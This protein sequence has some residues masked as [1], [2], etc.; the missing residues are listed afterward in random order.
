MGVTIRRA[1]PDDAEALT[2]L[3]NLLEAAGFAT[4]PAFRHTLEADWPPGTER[5]VAEDGGEIVALA[6]CRVAT[7]RG[8]WAWVGVLPPHRGAGLGGTLYARLETLLREHDAAI[9]RA[10]VGADGG[11]F[12]RSRGFTL[13]NEMRMQALDLAT[14]ELP[15]EP[16]GAVSLRETGA[17]T[18]RDLY[19]RT[20]ADIPGL[21]P[22]PPVTDEE[23]R[24]Q[25]AESEIVDLDASVVLLEDGEAVAF[26]LVVGSREAGRAGA[27]MTGVRAD[28]R[29]RGL[30]QRVKIASL[31]RTRAAGYARM[32]TANDVENEPMLAVNRK[33]GFEPT[34]AIG[35]YEKFL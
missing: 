16:A 13:A 17:W 27:Q 29:G 12:A 5:L 1:V 35:Q 9:V 28:R 6:R 2:A 4:V 19:A 14:A 25:V 15:P 31:H 10:T 11:A 21:T 33:L 26:A 34:V 30:A 18:I 20:T 3:T 7:G 32:L 8:G 23:F 22:R 24:R